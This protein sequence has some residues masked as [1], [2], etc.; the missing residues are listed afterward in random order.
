MRRPPRSIVHRLLV[1]SVFLTC[2]RCGPADPSPFPD[3]GDR[4]GRVATLT[5]DSAGGYYAWQGQPPAPLVGASN[6]TV[7]FLD[8]RYREDLAYL[9]KTGGDYVRTELTDAGGSEQFWGALSQFVDYAADLGV[10]V[11]ID[12]WDVDSIAAGQF[13]SLTRALTG[14]QLYDGSGE[15]TFVVGEHPFLQTV[16]EAIAYDATLT[17][18]LTAQQARV[19]R[20]LRATA[21]RGN[22]I[23]NLDVPAPLY[24]PW[25]VY[26]ARYLEERLPNSALVNAAVTSPPRLSVA[27]FNQAVLGGAAVAYHRP[28]PHGNGM[29]G[30]ALTSLRGI[31]TIERHLSFAELSP[32]PHLLTNDSPARAAQDPAGNILIYLPTAGSVSVYPEW[33]DEPTVDVTVVGYLGTQ[34]TEVL[35]PPYGEQFTLYTDEDKGGW[36]MLR[37]RRTN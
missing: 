16:P 10:A 13:D 34:R 21:G 24:I 36:M 8:G 35:E 3:V 23:Y 27:G 29:N 19:D 12:V 28:P 25:M 15:A 17:D 33:A 20:L 2:L 32:A 26:W 31:R 7:P 11:E 30:L 14:R 37:P 4:D 1:L 6:R 9:A 22:V 18:L 5:R